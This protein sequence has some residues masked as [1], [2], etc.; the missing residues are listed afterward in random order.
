MKEKPIVEI[1]ALNYY[2]FVPTEGGISR[3]ICSY[4]II[5]RK[6]NE[7]KWNKLEKMERHLVTDIFEKNIFKKE[8][9]K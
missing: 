6:Q 8:K 1:K 4:D 3:K 7:K 5:Y 9:K 2:Y